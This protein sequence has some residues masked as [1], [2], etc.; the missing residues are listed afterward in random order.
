MNF[1]RLS[2]ETTMNEMNNAALK[3]VAVYDS[4]GDQKLLEIALYCLNKMYELEVE[5]EY[6]L[7]NIF[8]I[9]KR[10]GIL[11]EKDIEILNSWN[12]Q[13][14]DVMFAQSVLLDDKDSAK[15]HWDKM[16]KELKKHLKKY[17]IFNLYNKLSMQ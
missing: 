8:Q 15:K 9:K 6:V 13:N 14:L 10:L 4:N 3:L 7:I 1:L 17:P 12:N 2:N 11:D 16:R 5:R